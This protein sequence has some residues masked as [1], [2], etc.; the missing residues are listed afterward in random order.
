LQVLRVL[1]AQCGGVCRR[2]MSVTSEG[3]RSDNATHR[4][5]KRKLPKKPPNTKR[6]PKRHPQFFNVGS[7][8]KKGESVALRGLSILAFEDERSEGIRSIQKL[9]ASVNPAFLGKVSPSNTLSTRRRIYQSP[10]AQETSSDTPVSLDSN[11]PSLHTRGPT[12]PIDVI[13]R[14]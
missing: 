5:K 12:K 8:P 13:V 1:S 3:T 10:G 7:Q 4:T 2:V 11:K 14:G 9:A 6:M